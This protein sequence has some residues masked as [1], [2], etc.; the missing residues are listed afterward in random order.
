MGDVDSEDSGY[1]TS[2][3]EIF[4]EECRIVTDDGLTLYVEALGGTLSWDEVQSKSGRVLFNYSIAGN[5]IHENEFP[6]VLN[7]FYP[8]VEKRVEIL[9]GASED[10]DVNRGA[11]PSNEG[12][13]DVY[14]NPNFVSLLDGPAMPYEVGVGGGYI[15]INVL[16]YATTEGF[17]P[18]MSLV[19]DVATSNASTALFQL[20][21]KSSEEMVSPTANLRTMWHTF[22]VGED[23]A[24]RIEGV[25]R[26]AFFWRWWSDESALVKYLKEYTSIMTNT[27]LGGSSSRVLEV[28]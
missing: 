10:G 3:G 22:Y 25:S 23:I 18:E 21:G 5:S 17:V 14:S 19:W 15:N 24:G 7:R 20:V 26:Y 27:T 1:I 12:G 13:F 16:Y 11:G 6:V 8:L 4:G 9:E 2:F 28:E